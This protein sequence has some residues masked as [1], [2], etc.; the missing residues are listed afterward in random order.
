LGPGLYVHLPSSRYVRPNK[1]LLHGIDSVSHAPEALGQIGLCNLYTAGRRKT[2]GP[3]LEA[4]C[5]VS[6][7]GEE[8]GVEIIALYGQLRQ[9]EA[10]RDRHISR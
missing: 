7:G 1:R 9:R 8:K 3:T 6:T 10:L 2:A 5:G 4:H